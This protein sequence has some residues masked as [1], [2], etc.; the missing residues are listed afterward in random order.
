MYLKVLLCY[1]QVFPGPVLLT[2]GRVDDALE[3]VLLGH[4]G[5]LG[6]IQ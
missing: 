6:P 1:F 2:N 3:D 4:G 5:F